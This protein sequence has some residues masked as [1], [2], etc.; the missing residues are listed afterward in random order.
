MGLG[1]R[2]GLW[3]WLGLELFHLLP[4][5]LVLKVAEPQLALLHAVP[6]A[7]KLHVLR[8]SLRLERGLLLVVEPLDGGVERLD[9]AIESADGVFPGVHLV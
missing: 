8:A 7:L 3:L 4:A 1:L 6:R 5:H 2:L 9:L